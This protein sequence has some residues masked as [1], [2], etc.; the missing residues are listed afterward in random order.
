MHKKKKVK[1][2]HKIKQIIDSILRRYNS[3]SE[4]D[5]KYCLSILVRS[6]IF[7][8]YGHR[9]VIYVYTFLNGVLITSICY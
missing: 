9:C 2:E 7:S 8:W 5:E 1:G 4:R 6:D 3:H